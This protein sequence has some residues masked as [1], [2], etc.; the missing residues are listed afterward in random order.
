MQH[1]LRWVSPFLA[2]VLAGFVTAADTKK[3]TTT[4][5][6]KKIQSSGSAI[7]KLTVLE[8]STKNFAVQLEFYE[9]DPNKVL[10]LEKYKRDVAL[11]LARTTNPID[12]RNKAVN[13]A[14]EIKKREADLYRKVHKDLKLEPAEDMKVRWKNPP[15]VYDDNGKPK[16]LT[17]KE[18][19]KLK[20]PNKKLIG[21]EASPENLRV[22]QMVRVYLAK[23]KKKK[24][25][26]EKEEGFFD[27]RHK[28]VMVLI[29]Q[30][31]TAK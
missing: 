5:E 6:T 24:S 7:G 29:L 28:A 25:K 14:V 10:G 18:R 15:V 13:Y 9:P 17:P 22:N 12:R 30:D 16:K 27:Q 11:D 26:D 21:Y 8:G 20:G 23:E 31:P 1:S 2:L 19:L 3:T 4:K